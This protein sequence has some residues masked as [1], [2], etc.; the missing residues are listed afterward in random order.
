MP[1]N[2]EFPAGKQSHIAIARNALDSGVCD[3]VMAVSKKMWDEIFN[4]GKTMAGYD[5]SMKETMDWTLTDF[6]S[7]MPSKEI[8]SESIELDGIIFN[9]LGSVIKQYI[10]E[11]SGM[12]SWVRGM[13]DTS[14]LVQVYKRGEGFYKPHVDAAPWLGY[15]QSL[16]ALACVMYLNTVDEGGETE[17][18]EHGLKVSPKQGTML[19][20]P[21]CWTHPHAARIPISGDKWII[22]TFVAHDP[23]SR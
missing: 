17:F 19:M 11:Y 12:D 15:P 21:A 4:P 1:S 5:P 9:S 8:V 10:A 2:L 16:R 7:H 13:R 18:T 20:F 3:R 6:S 14:Y 22:S 23:D